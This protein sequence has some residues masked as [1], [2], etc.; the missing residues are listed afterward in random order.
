MSQNNN[1]VFK[2]V[3]Q[4]SFSLL[5]ILGIV[6][7]WCKYLIIPETDLIFK[8][9]TYGRFLEYLEMGWIKQVDFYDNDHVAIVQTYTPELGNQQSVKVEIPMVASQLIPKL[10][11]YNINFDAHSF[12]KKGLF[13]VSDP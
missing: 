5:F 7:T 12:P 10:K 13:K 9:M 6:N 11:D 3:F 8:Y 4:V 2:I 1:N